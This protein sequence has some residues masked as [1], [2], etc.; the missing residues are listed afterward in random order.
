MLS[1]SI[2]HDTV[3]SFPLHLDT[4]SPYELAEDVIDR[5]S[6]GPLSSVLTLS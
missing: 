1:K 4:Q 5:I 6:T 2:P 3:H